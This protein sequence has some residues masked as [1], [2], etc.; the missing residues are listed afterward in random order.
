[1]PAAVFSVRNAG[2]HLRFPMSPGLVLIA[3]NAAWS[4]VKFGVR[5][6][7]LTAR[8]AILMGDLDLGVSAPEKIS[9]LSRS[10][11]KALLKDYIDSHEGEIELLPRAREIF[12]AQPF[13]PD[14][15]SDFLAFAW[16]EKVHDLDHWESGVPGKDL[17]KDERR[18]IL[19]I[20]SMAA[21]PPIAGEIILLATE[22]IASAGSGFIPHI[23]GQNGVAMLVQSVLER[24]AEVSADG[25]GVDAP[26]AELSRRALNA[27]LDAVVANASALKGRNDLLDLGLDAVSAMK[28]QTGDGDWKDLISS[29]FDEGGFVRLTGALAAATASANVVDARL[30]PFVVDV[31]TDLSAKLRGHTGPPKNFLKK[32][33]P[34]LVAGGL[35]V[36]RS[37]GVAPSASHT[38]WLRTV[39]RTGADTLAAV[40]DDSN[41]GDNGAIAGNIA[42]SL[43]A[44]IGGTLIS[45]PEVLD[46]SIG[47]TELKNLLLAVIKPLSDSGHL[48]KPGTALTLGTS[49][50]AGFLSLAANDVSLRDKL[51]SAEQMKWFSGVASQIYRLTSGPAFSLLLDETTRVAMSGNLISATLKILARCGVPDE[52][53]VETILKKFLDEI[54]AAAADKRLR[55]F[56]GS[57]GVRELLEAASKLAAGEPG[58]FA[59]FR[60]SAPAVLPVLLNAIRNTVGDEPARRSR[61]AVDLLKTLGNWLA[62]RPDIHDAEIRPFVSSLA[63]AFANTARHEP[64]TDG[65]L[66]ANMISAIG[67]ALKTRVDIGYLVRPE[68]TGIALSIIL[69]HPK[70]PA[71]PLVFASS[72]IPVHVLA[73]TGP[74][75]AAVLVA[76][77]P[78]IWE[79][80]I[81]TRVTE[82]INNALIQQPEAQPEAYFARQRIDNALAACL[83]ARALAIE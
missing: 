34:D 26:S 82:A 20:K 27:G 37:T 45:T 35:S 46:A 59:G 50:A 9:N 83:A 62:V 25:K 22:F 7:R 67:D 17:T 10:E 74:E 33:W 69:N 51:L 32:H 18:G 72:R 3:V 16:P 48:E 19:T 76:I 41:F 24:Y 6:D 13:S 23:L 2:R 44:T 63:K 28:A 60:D 70:W 64:P 8:K 31:A 61:I 68:T 71:A 47:E 53:A 77:S 5:V 54:S 38:E 79:K 42:S 75:E 58:L 65:I 81:T 78:E 11:W 43:I 39:V 4:A 21:A 55:A 1:M 49:L 57:D 12:D 29:Y 52:N 30:K 15:T 80:R 14:R 73:K 40:F 56:A 36:L 66:L